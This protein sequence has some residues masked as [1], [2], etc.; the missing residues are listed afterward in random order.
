MTSRKPSI[1]FVCAVAAMVGLVVLLQVVRE[2]AFAHEAIDEQVLY[3]RSGEVLKRAAL[4][5]DALLADVYW[6]RALQHFG[7]ERLKSAG[8]RR[9]DL[10]YPL[11][12]LSTT[13]D[14]LFTVA[15]R[16]GAIF[17]AEPRP[18][19]AG[20]PDQAIALLEKGIASN[21]AKWDYYLDI[22]FI[23]YWN[24]HDYQRAAEWFNRGGEVPGAPWWLKTYAA[25][26]LTRGGDRQASRAMWQ[27]IGQSEENEWLRQTSQ[28]RL[29]QLDALDQI[30]A[31]R[32]ILTEF[33]KRTGSRA[34]SW[35]P[36]IAE[37]LLRGVPVD[38]ARIP[39]T[40]DPQTGDIG[41]ARESPLWPLPTEPAAAPEL[42]N[43]MPPVPR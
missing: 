10:L 4:S 30:D 15:Y 27:Q 13:L 38:P 35:Q 39:Y 12:D 37:G 17:L 21:P 14:P 40:L 32:R 23:Y 6:I 34:Q 20:R 7:R 42:T 16:F 26:M 28:V 22:G 11:L 43:A 36:V 25:V 8:D 9:F 3:I 29:A 24:L 5:Y 41:V 2:R 1:A 18:G 19:G 31:L 33:S